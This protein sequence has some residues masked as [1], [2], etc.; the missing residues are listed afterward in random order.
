MNL[1]QFAETIE[2]DA[3]S[4]ETG[5]PSVSP[6]TVVPVSRAIV[7]VLREADEKIKQ[8]E[9]REVDMKRIA[10]DHRK[11]IG[12]LLAQAQG[13]TIHIRNMQ[14]ETVKLREE[15]AKLREENAKFVAKIVELTI[16]TE[17]NGSG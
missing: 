14:T 4:L 9:V 15:N 7:G 17:N 10:T 16:I 1:L 11:E 2:R 5:L 3:K 13:H 6:I 8:M 12:R